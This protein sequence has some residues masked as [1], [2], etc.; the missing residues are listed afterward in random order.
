M[1]PTFFRDDRDRRAFLGK[2]LQDLFFLLNAQMGVVYRDRGVVIPV[3]LSSTLRFV[4]RCGPVSISQ[5]AAGLAASHQLISLRVATLAELRLVDG[6][7]D[8]TDRRRR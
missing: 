5:I 1:E 6:R 4:E 7:P 8:A 3:E 2:G